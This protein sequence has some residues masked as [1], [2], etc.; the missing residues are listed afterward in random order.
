MSD[1]VAKGDLNFKSGKALEEWLETQPREVSVIIAA[2]A[3]LRVLPFAAR[4]LP[5]Q[6]VARFGALISALF[7]ATALARVA[8]KYPTR[9][10][11]LAAAGAFAAAYA[12]AA[13]T[14]STDRAAAAAAFAADAADADANAYNSA[15]TSARAAATATPLGAAWAAFSSDAKFLSR[16]GVVE[17]LADIPLWPRGTAPDVVDLWGQ[18]KAALPPNEE[19]EIWTRWYD[20]RLGG[21]LSRGEAYELVFATVPEE[22]WNKGPAAANRWIKEHL[23]PP[24]V[25]PLDNIP[26]LFTFGWSAS[27]KITVVAGPQNLPFLPFAVS[28][29]DHKQ[30][31]ETS[32]VQVERLLADLNAK[33]L[34]VRPDY[35]EAL[36]RYKADLPTAPGQG[37][38][39]LAD[40]EA[41]FL[42]DLFAAEADFIPAPF[43]LRLKGVLQQH[44]ALRGFYPEVER[45]YSA[46]QKGHIEKPLPWDNVEAFGRAIRENTPDK[47]EPEVSKGLQEVERAPPVVELEPEDIRRDPNAILPPPDPLGPVKPENSRSYSVASVVNGIMKVVV[48]GKDVSQAFDG[49][50]HLAHK[51][52]EV[53]A[54][55]IGWLRDN[56]PQI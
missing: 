30:W 28:E 39:V 46:I 1:G 23:P 11:E 45:L 13:S 5:A 14:A 22:I 56:F 37:N 15:A 31:L 52:G 12:F 21:A 9:A 24:R 16:G 27:H 32:R 26:S 18:L 7:R 17:A 25:K 20:E 3:A 47:F 50:E 40:Q 42:R 35:C 33:Q 54:P 34:N 41:R 2:R 38:F 8:A 29:A 51:L 19:W 48:R 43:A 10:N 49:W 6:D 4:E 55:I 36:E 44:I 53:A